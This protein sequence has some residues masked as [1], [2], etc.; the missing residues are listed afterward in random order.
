[1][2]SG[3]FFLH[4]RRQ[5]SSIRKRPGN[6]GQRICVLQSHR[7]ET[8]KFVHQMVSIQEERKL[9]GSSEVNFHCSTCESTNVTDAL[10]FK[11]TDKLWGFLTVWKT[12]ETDVKCPN[13][14]T[15]HRTFATL[16]EL[17]GLTPEQL[18]QRFRVRVGLV[19]KFLVVGGI[20]LSCSGPVSLAMLGIAYF[21]LL[22]KAAKG[23]RK[24]AILGAILPMLITCWVTLV[25]TVEAFRK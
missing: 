6:L 16:E 23:W 11:T 15:T 5:E 20:V 8:R 17:E 1:M 19:E 22:P 10:R 3:R 25:L 18:G 7:V 21:F 4:S 9:V 2:M 12:S 24:A 14:G 13:C